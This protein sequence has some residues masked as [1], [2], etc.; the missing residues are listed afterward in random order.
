MTKTILTAIVVLTLTLSGYVGGNAAEEKTIDS[1]D[2]NGVIT[3]DDGSQYQT[4]DEV[5]DWDSGDTVLVLDSGDKLIN[6]DQGNEEVD[7]EPSSVVVAS[8]YCHGC[9]CKSG[10]GWRKP[11]GHCAS[12]AE[13]T[14]V[15]HSPPGPPCKYEGAPQ[16]CPPGS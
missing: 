4:N 2:N 9:G 1:I 3:M 12:H 10:P 14:E 5:S 16:V 8:C 7:A 15:C 13:L 11:D 6:R